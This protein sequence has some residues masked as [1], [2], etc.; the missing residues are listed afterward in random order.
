V[1]NIVLLFSRDLTPADIC[2][3]VEDCGGQWMAEEERGIA[4]S[5]RPEVYVDWYPIADL[6]VEYE[7]DHWKRVLETLGAEPRSAISVHYSSSSGA[8]ARCQCIADEALRRWDGVMD[9]ND[10]QVTRTS[11]RSG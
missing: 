8:F 2:G 5:K 9:W 3:L 10:G 7:V 6:Q 1:E 4:P 11:A